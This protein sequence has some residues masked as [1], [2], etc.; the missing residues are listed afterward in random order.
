MTVE[1]EYKGIKKRYKHVSA[2]RARNAQSV[3][4][5]LLGEA[6]TVVVKK[7]RDRPP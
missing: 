7:E 4:K 3:Y 1:I 5:N 6:V 2:A